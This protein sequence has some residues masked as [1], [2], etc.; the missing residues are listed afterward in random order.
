[1]GDGR[2][3]EPATPAEGAVP[4]EPVRPADGSR[5]P[6]T[7]DRA[8]RAAVWRQAASIGIATG[9]Y[10]LSFGALGVTSGLSLLQTCALSLLMFTG[11]SQFAFAGVIG[12]GG[13]GVA[14]VA[15][16]GLLGARNG[17]YGLQMAPLLRPSGWRR[18][19]AAQVTIDEST[20][21]GL[22]QL[23][24]H[25]GRL[26]LARLG[27]WTTAGSVFALW[28][29]STVGGALLGDALG[30]PRRFGLDAA[31][32]AAF[33]ALLWPRLSTAV[34]RWVALGGAGTAAVLVPIAP[35]GVPVLAA[36]L[37]GVAAGFPDRRRRATR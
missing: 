23:A 1:M 10:G 22:A 26:D 12:A 33:I 30:D 15:T 2:T 20:A 21:V 4:P 16:A 7:A 37:V 32:A 9:A 5:A 8:L 36:A 25:P 11:G 29:L 18:P 34:P 31:A 27:F 28:N 19:L 35:A 13:S 3:R 14:A 24:L 17:F 6:A